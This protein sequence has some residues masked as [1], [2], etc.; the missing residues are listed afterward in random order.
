MCVLEYFHLSTQQKT[1]TKNLICKIFLLDAL[2]ALFCF[3]FWN[4]RLIVPEAF[5]RLT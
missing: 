3:Y 4:I 5:M 1:S 2:Y